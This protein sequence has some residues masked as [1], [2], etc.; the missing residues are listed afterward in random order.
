MFFCADCTQFGSLNT[1]F[2]S[3]T[4]SSSF[5]NN[6]KEIMTDVHL[7]VYKSDYSLHS[8]NI[9]PVIKLTKLFQTAN[10]R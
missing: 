8:N 2:V 6:S 5:M 9:A 4:I 1:A 10:S 3:R 7:Q